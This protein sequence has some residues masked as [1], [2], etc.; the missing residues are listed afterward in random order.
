MRYGLGGIFVVFS[1]NFINTISLL[2]WRQTQKALQLPFFSFFLFRRPG[3]VF[4][5][6]GKN[7]LFI[8]LLLLL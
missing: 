7:Y 3:A 6:T 1:R 8:F 2:R 5:R 4:G